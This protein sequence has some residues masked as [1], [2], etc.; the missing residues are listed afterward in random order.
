M[1]PAVKP[2][3]NSTRTGVVGVMATAGTFESQRYASLMERY[4]AD[5]TLLEDPCAGL[6]ELIE[7]GETASARTETVLRKVLEPMLSVGMDTLILGCTHYPFAD[8]AIRRV[9]GPGVS[10][11]DPAPAVA[12]QV[13][14]VLSAADHLA[15]RD[16]AGSVRLFTSGEPRR[17]AQQTATLLGE[18]WPAEGVV[19]REGALLPRFTNSASPV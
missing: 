14:R 19:W 15:Q 17:L 8:A 6:V 2:G 9:V 5:I 3:A 13:F 11:I 10:V 18:H 16:G 7:A 1:E 4:A 12:R